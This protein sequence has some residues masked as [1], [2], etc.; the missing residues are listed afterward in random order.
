MAYIGKR[1][2]DTFPAINAITSNLIA[3]NNITAREIATGAVSTSLLAANSI[4]SALVAANS[5]D[6]SEIK[7][8]AVRSL[9]IQ[10][11]AVTADQIATLTGHVLFNDNAQIK[12]GTSQDLLIY[13][14]GTN[15]YIDD[16]GTGA[17][18]IR[19]NALFLEKPDGSEVMASFI[20]DGS[21]DLY[22]N[23]V[24]KFETTS[25]GATVTGV[26]TATVTGNVTG[27]LTGTASAVADDAVTSGKIATGAVLT[28]KI[29]DN[30]VTSS[31]I[32]DGSIGATQLTATSVSAGSYGSA[33]A[34]P[35]ITVDAD[36]R[37][38][39]A[40]T[41][42]VA[43][44]L[45]IGADSGSDDV[46]TIG[47]DTLTIA[48]GGNITTT[49]SNN[50]VSIALDASPT[51]TGNLVVD[52]N[53]TVS[54]TTTT[55]NTTNVSVADPLTVLSS[56]ETGTPS[57]DSGL[58][59]ERGTASNTG[60]I[61][62]ESA[63]RWSAVNTTEDGTTAGNVTIASY[64][65]IQGANFYGNGANLTGV[66]STLSA[67]TDTT[68]SS[69][70]GGNM[71]IYDGTNSWDNVVMS[72]DATLAANGT[73]TIASQAVETGMIASGAITS[74]LLA[75]NSVTAAK[76]PNGSILNEHLAD[77]A[78]GADELA[79]SAVVEASIVNASV[80]GA[81]IA[82]NTITVANIADNAVDATKIASNSI[83]TRHIDDN[84]ITGDQIAD[85]IVLS[86]TGS[87]RVP[88]GTTAQR[89]GSAALGM[90]RFNTDN[91]LF[92]GY[93]GSWG[94][95]G[96][97]ESNFTT[98]TFTGDGSQA[99]V[100]LSQIPNSEDN[101]MVF[102]EGVYQNKTD[103]VLSGARITFDTAPAN[104]RTIVVHH[105]KAL[106]A[107]GNTNIDTYS[108]STASPNN[109]NGS[110]VAFA[111]SLAPITQ[112][113]TQVFIDGVYQQKGSYATSGTTITFSEA[114]P[115]TS[116]VEVMIFTQTSINVP[117]DGSVTLAKIADQGTD[118]QVLTS[119]G[120]GVAWETAG[121]GSSVAFKTFGTN[122]LMVGDTTTGT[123]DA[124]DNNTG[125]GVDVFAS[126]TTGDNNTAIG[127]KAG[128]SLA[129][130]DSRNT[131][132]GSYAG[133]SNTG[134]ANIAIGYE[135][136]KEWG[137]SNYLTAI[138]YQ[139]LGTN[140]GT[141]T[142]TRN[143]V[144]I[145]NYAMQNLKDYAASPSLSGDSVAVGDYAHQGTADTEAYRNTAIGFKALKGITTGSTC[146]AVG[147]QA[148]MSN[149]TSQRTIAI[150]GDALKM[151]TANNTGTIAIGYN[152]LKNATIN[153]SNVAIGMS[154][155]SSATAGG[156]NVSLGIY[157]FLGLT[158]GYQNTAIG[159]N[160]AQ[161]M[162]TGRNT[163]ALGYLSG[164]VL[165]TGYNNIY[166]GMDTHASANN[167]DNEIVIGSKRDGYNTVDIVGKG[168]ST[169]FIA[170]GLTGAVYQGNNSASW[171][172]TSDRRIK[173]NI[174]D[175]NTGLEAIKQIQV[176]NFEYRTQDEITD[177]E[178]PASAAVRKEG[179]Q[180]G[181]IAQEIEEILPDVVNE[182]STGVKSVNP[183][184]ITWYLVNAIKE[185]QAQIEE[186]KKKIGE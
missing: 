38:T 79:A 55:V 127:Y 80:T 100:D 114:P 89:P 146:V 97:G 37:L 78:V 154:S 128:T 3:E 118:G 16:I 120:S 83:L 71:L 180:L 9:Q 119:T 61:W 91:N 76:I 88:D 172:T 54:G 22:H 47:T 49:V 68:I 160:S 138:G 95:I 186:L 32:A 46:V 20:G 170:P 122:S 171:A 179:V 92:E 103:Y 116:T 94:G 42:T 17:L 12:L 164:Q 177:F 176:R 109:V 33:S 147:Y 132:V 105:V 40:S 60:W 162:T 112:N 115:S 6:A 11:D 41:A 56:G 44:S 87:L 111:L 130:G 65:D 72:G 121:A 29:A 165:T 151:A 34:V 168:S 113:N 166:V 157:S 125:L 159:N 93:S 43:G 124:A 173:K 163:V 133:E 45:T 184:N 143:V 7:T 14:N 4:T 27:N 25:A 1:P 148:G 102:I 28:S 15:S 75:A 150:G 2:V 86:G 99:Y 23:N 141:D 96:G 106:V 131:F 82:A 31:K 174:E 51:V 129:S 39:A 182:E 8:D 62:D 81:K 183:D 58:I 77:D 137:S 101:L 74:G 152:A 13:H 110:R 52:G 175:N 181:V 135:S 169:G 117:T 90:V 66:V 139:A 10:D 158:V 149:T 19:S 59:V 50:Q 36:G 155:Q 18:N 104:T 70:A 145:G 178:N 107:G 126:L 161:H 136:L 85:D 67:L 26:L 153:N 63:D 185:Q 5:I 69:L 123:I 64:A 35:I 24:K 48:G 108:S 167:V 134:F 57:K 140:N 21:V 98:Q 73:I 142:G 156:G 30:A 84:Q 144:A 53:L